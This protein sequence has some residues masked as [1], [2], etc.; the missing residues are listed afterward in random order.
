MSA[1][2]YRAVDNKG[3]AIKNRIDAATP[4]E[5]LTKIRGLGY[6]PTHIKEI[7]TRQKLMKY[8]TH[9]AKSA[10]KY[11]SLSVGLTRKI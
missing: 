4:D 7:S 9:P 5:A 2:Q 11:P 10:E 1:F 8:Q 3:Q 6:F